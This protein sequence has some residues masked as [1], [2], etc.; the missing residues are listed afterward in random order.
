MAITQT[1]LDNFALN[2]SCCLATKSIDVINNINAGTLNADSIMI[3]A[4]AAHLLLEAIYDYDIDS[5]C[6]TDD[7]IN[8]IAEQLNKYCCE[9]C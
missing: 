4:M 7:E 9:C 1:E 5:E 6:L 8:Y 3:N 2:R